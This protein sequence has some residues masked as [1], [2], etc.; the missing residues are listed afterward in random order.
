MLDACLKN[1]SKVWLCHMRSVLMNGQGGTLCVVSGSQAQV[2]CYRHRCRCRGLWLLARTCGISLELIGLLLLFPSILGFATGRSR[3]FDSSGECK[4]T[5][6][7][8]VAPLTRLLTNSSGLSG[9]C[10]SC[11]LRHPRYACICIEPRG[12][13][14][15]YSVR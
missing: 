13:V 2:C 5:S 15:G 8:G 11:S 4:G 10:T 6:R 7:R 12:T 1:E 9:R 3:T 14:D